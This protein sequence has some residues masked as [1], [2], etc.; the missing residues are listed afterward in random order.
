M[1]IDC[2]TCIGQHTDA[3]DD[4]VVTFILHSGSSLDLETEELEALDV[5]AEEGLVPR[6]RLIVDPQL[7]T[8]NADSTGPNQLGRNQL[9]E[10]G[11]AAGLDRIGFTTADPFA[12][13]EAEIDQRN[14]T[15]LSGGLG[16]TYRDPQAATDVRLHF[17]WA[18]SLVVG[19]RAYR[20]SQQVDQNRG[21]RCRC[22]APARVRASAAGTQGDPRSVE[23]RGPPS[24]SAVRRQPVG[25]SSGGGEGR[26]RL[27]GKEHHGPRSGDRAVV[28]HR[29]GRHRSR[30]RTRRADDQ[31]LR[32]LFGVPSCLSH[33]RTGCPRHVGCPSLFGR[34]GANAGHRSDRTTGSDGQPAL[35]MR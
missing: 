8:A 18:E 29:I 23:G 28:P 25:R 16:F 35:W 19:A 31:R 2:D 20:P 10:V 30:G 5:L 6:L 26:D 17:P 33:R 1:H 14:R 15:G 32:E 21:R 34:L 12:A 24:R 27:V 7:K 3:C 4:C 13:V 9:I 22:G 11:T